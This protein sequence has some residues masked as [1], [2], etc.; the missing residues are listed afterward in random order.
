MPSLSDD[1]V[2]VIHASDLA[3]ALLKA[4]RHGRRIS[5]SSDSS[6][7][8]YFAAAEE[9]P[10]YADLGRMIGQALGRK[11]TRVMRSPPALVWGISAANEMIAQ[12]RR[13]PHILNL[14]KA[15]EATAGSWSCSSDALRADT[16]FRPASSLQQRLDETARWSVEEG[17]LP[18]RNLDSTGKKAVELASVTD[19]K[20][21]GDASPHHQ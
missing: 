12:L 7:G 10:T 21:H 2:S 15:R 17:W 6:T 5:P 19:S 9:T 1:R 14:D 16:G 4:A 8:I 13:R 11:K 20:L 3:D 18:N